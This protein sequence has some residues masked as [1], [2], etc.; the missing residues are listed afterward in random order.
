VYFQFSRAPPAGIHHLK[1]PP[2]LQAYA[3]T[4]P[5]SA[6]DS[7]RYPCSLNQNHTNNLDKARVGFGI[8]VSLRQTGDT[9]QPV[10]DSVW[11][12]SGLSPHE[13]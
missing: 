1:S 13:Q 2:L 12:E 4:P 6:G 10:P 3:S 7:Y 8:Y 5:P 9:K 11:H